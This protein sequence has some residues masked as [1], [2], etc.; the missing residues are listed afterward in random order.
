[1]QFKLLN[2]RALSTGEPCTCQYVTFLQSF[3]RGTLSIHWYIA[4]FKSLLNM[5]VLEERL[6][7]TDIENVG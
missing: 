6:N 2:E 4:T 5:A 3:H 1:M 7:K